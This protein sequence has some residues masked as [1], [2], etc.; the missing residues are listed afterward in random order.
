MKRF[1]KSILLLAAAV[2]AFESAATAQTLK[3]LLKQAATAAT[4]TTT[5]VSKA[6]TQGQ[7][8]GVALK[9][10]YAQYKTDGKKLDMKN[11]SN[12][13]SIAS[14]AENVKGLKTADASF[15]KDYAK[16]LISGSSE[17]VKE[18]QTTSVLSGLTSLSNMD[19]SSLTKN[20]ALQNAASQVLKEKANEALTD[21]VSTSKLSQV[22]QKANII[23]SQAS[24]TIENASAIASSVSGILSMF[25]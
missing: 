5:T 4:T 14:L 13:L 17:L 1:C 25:K 21:A 15:K 6:Y 11:V 24:G 3:G 12:I 19:L 23:A 20:V 22:A 8:S 10:L 18:E 16:G 7:N 2:I 9:A